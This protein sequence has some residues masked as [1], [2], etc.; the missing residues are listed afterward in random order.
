MHETLSFSEIYNMVDT[1]NS[2][3]C[4][5]QNDGLFSSLVGDESAHG[6]TLGLSRKWHRING[7][8]TQQLLEGVN[9]YVT[10]VV[11]FWSFLQSPVLS[12]FPLM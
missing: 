10:A 6:I 8:A 7:L 3:L 9:V 4:F 5:C 1:D 2:V 11:T 12:F